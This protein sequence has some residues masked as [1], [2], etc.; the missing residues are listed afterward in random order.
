[1]KYMVERDAAEFE[2][3]SGAASRMD[4]AKLAQREA[5]CERLEEILTGARKRRKTTSMILFGLSVM[6]FLMRNK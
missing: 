4:D 5:V 6:I 3:W 2:F 1:M